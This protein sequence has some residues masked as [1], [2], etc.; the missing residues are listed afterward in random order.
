[1][2]NQII[3]EKIAFVITIIIILVIFEMTKGG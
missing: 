3:I 1:M 2:I